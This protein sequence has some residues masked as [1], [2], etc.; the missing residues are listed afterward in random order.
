MFLAF[1]LSDIVIVPFSYL[2]RFLYQLVNNYGLAL[3]LFTILVKVILIPLTA[4]GKKS[5][6]QMSRMTPY[7]KQDFLI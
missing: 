2:L 1:Q 5:T 3:I 7:K 4:K 6:M